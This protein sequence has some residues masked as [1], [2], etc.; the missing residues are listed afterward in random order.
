M[1]KLFTFLMIM[2]FVVASMAQVMQE[3]YVQY[4]LVSSLYDN[5]ACMQRAQIEGAWL[6][7]GINQEDGLPCLGTATVTDIDGNIYNTVKIGDQC[8]MKE[9]LRTTRYADGTFI[10]LS[11]GGSEKKACRYNPNNDAGNVPMYGYLYN[12]YAVMHDASS[13]SSNP[14]GIQGICPTGWHV[15][16]DAE[17][18][19][20]EDYVSGQTKYQCDGSR[21]D[22]AKALASTIGWDISSK[23]CSIGNNPSTNNATGFSA[24]PAGH[25]D[26]VD[27]GDGETNKYYNIGRRATFWSA[28]WDGEG[29]ATINALFYHNSFCRTG[30]S[31]MRNGY[32]VRCVRD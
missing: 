9:N 25:F 8:W 28:T 20:L 19:Q 17:W 21:F 7:S 24:L 13:S 16:S 12:W 27:N 1:K 14:S 11:T 3:Q 32:S 18:T 26:V 5:H 4:F 6:N 29:F 22:I 23:T 31:L 30:N 10:P 2:V 15:P